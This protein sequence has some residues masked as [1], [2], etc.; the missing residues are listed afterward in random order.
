MLPLARTAAP[1][2]NIK[3]VA[4]QNMVA[5][6]DVDANRLDKGAANYQA[7]RKYR[8]F[9]VMLEK[10]ADKLDAVVVATPDHTHAPAAAMAL[11]M[12][13]HVYCEK[14]LTHTVKEARVLAELA[15]RNN[16]VTQMG[17]QIHAKNNYRRVVELI[18]SEAIGP[19]REAHVW[20]GA[21]YTG[22]K[23]TT[24]TPAPDHFELGPLARS[25]ARTTVQ[26]RCA[27]VSVA[28]V[29]GLR[30]RY[31]WRLWLSLHGPDTL[32]APASRPD[33]GLCRRATRGFC[34]HATLLHRALSVPSAR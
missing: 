10:E 1:A 29:L 31:P 22:G 27:P 5:I 16:L 17:T 24:G 28:E 26:Q 25:R 3:A 12:K 32:G 14:P 6:A 2:G 9:R 34:Q 18:R 20:A 21:V 15:K 11:R 30:H 13:K 33:S 19:V 4:S 8:D 7:A 23:F